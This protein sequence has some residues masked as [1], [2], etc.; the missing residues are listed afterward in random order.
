MTLRKMVLANTCALALAALLSAACS[1]GGGSDAGGTTPT[2][3]PTPSGNEIHLGA[4]S[5]SPDNIT[6]S[7]GTT[8]HWINDTSTGHTITPNTAGQAG[9]W[10]SQ[11]ISGQGTTFDFTF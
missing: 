11:S 6:V 2:T 1:G 9:A 3:P 10:P 7:H 4:A 5:F 8:V